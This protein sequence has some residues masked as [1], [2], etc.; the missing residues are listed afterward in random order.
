MPTK[1]I[2][3]EDGTLVEVEAPPGEAEQISGGRM[4]DKVNS[5][6]SVIKPTLINA[7]LPLKDVWQELNKEMQ[8]SQA[9]VEIGV[10]FAAEGDVYIAKSKA[11]ANL[12]VKLIIKP[13]QEEQ[14]QES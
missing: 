14:E 6:L 10:S 12:K 4:A 5:T 7:C 11:E 9:E 8:V 3:L 1:L 2:R 13:Q